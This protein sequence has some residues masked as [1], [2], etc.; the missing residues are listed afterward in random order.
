KAKGFKDGKAKGFKDGKAKGFKD[1]KVEG[2][3]DGKAKGE[4]QKSREIARKMVAKG[5]EIEF[6]VDITGLTP[7]EIE[8]LK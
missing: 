3:K 2:F 5:A 7:D 6:I 8:A 1:G 4:K